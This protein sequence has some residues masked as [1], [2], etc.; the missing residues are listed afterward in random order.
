MSIRFKSV[1]K[2]FSVEIND[3]L[4]NIIK[5]ECVKA[6]NSETGGILIGGYSENNNN[7]IISSVTGPPKD[8]KKSKY[9]F[10]RGIIG[11]CKI[12]DTN[13]NLGY[14][15]LG[16]WHFHPNS[17]PQPSIIDDVQM[18]KF[19]KNDLLKC[20][21]PVLLIMGGNLNIGWKMSA[22]V[23]TK[24]EKITLI[25]QGKSSLNIHKISA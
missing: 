24:E 6:G 15:Y 7:A 18:Q 3:I 8:S 20:P 12:I 19:A 22:H 10:E 21:E 11:L 16:E 2:K 23:Y 5:R 17:S 25:K 9:G 14:Y 1:D 13:W 4:L